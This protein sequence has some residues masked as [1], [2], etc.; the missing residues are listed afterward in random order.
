MSIHRLFLTV[1]LCVVGT[2]CAQ[3]FPTGTVRIVSPYTAG[4]SNDAVARM[5]A[6]KLAERWGKPVIVENR[7]G[8]NAITG[9]DHV[10]KARPDGH[11]L[12]TIPAAHVT[13]PYLQQKM[14]FNPLT[15]LTA[16][17]IVG[18]IPFMLAV[19]PQLPVRNVKELVAH[20]RAHP[21]KLTFASNGAGSGAH[22][23]GELFAQAAEVQMLH[24]PYRGTSAALPDVLSG[25]VS[26]I[27]DA[28]Q[29]LA[30]HLRSGRLRPL[31]VTGGARWPTEPEVPTAAESGLPSLVAETW[32]ALVT[33]AGTP[34][35][36]AERIARDVT[37]VLEQPDVRERLN[38]FG[39]VP[40]GGTPAAANR[41]VADESAKWGRVIKSA[42]IKID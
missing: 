1:L 13:N 21:G 14:P 42:N 17:T 12:L 41:F 39:I 19:N 38:G 5:L 3:D 33:T 16:V 7:P 8:A 6:G 24:V 36:V 37:A 23:A 26:M 25:Q 11:T 31:A 10:A 22:L 30:P 35:A 40:V 15:D 18:T 27:F 29:P 32:I 4:G 9:S 2:V 20:A 28:I 34:S